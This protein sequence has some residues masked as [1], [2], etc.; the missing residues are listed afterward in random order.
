MYIHTAN[1]PKATTIYIFHLL[2]G[3]ILMHVNIPHDPI[4]TCH[5]QYKY[6]SSRGILKH[7]IYFSFSCPMWEN[8]S[9]F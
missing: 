6:C 1:K 4:V 8:L 7:N 2:L 5:I 3:F 9:C